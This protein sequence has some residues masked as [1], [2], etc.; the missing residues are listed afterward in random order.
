MG[1]RVRFCNAHGVVFREKYFAKADHRNKYIKQMCREYKKRKGWYYE[2]IPDDKMNVF[3][4][5]F[6]DI[7]LNDGPTNVKWF[8][9]NYDLAE[10]TIT[11]AIQFVKPPKGYLII[12]TVTA[13]GIYYKA[14][15]LNQP[16]TIKEHL[17][18]AV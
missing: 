8:S 10:A 13:D 7:L 15:C 12:K 5:I 17:S 11:N 1:S 2:I 16:R 9:E 14:I 4:H 18:F 6:H 3:V